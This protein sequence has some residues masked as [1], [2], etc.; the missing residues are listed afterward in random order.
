M[1]GFRGEVEDAARHLPVLG[2]EVAGVHGHLFERLDRRL[3]LIDAN[4][5]AMVVRFH[6]FDANLKRVQRSAADLQRAVRRDVPARH[7][8]HERVRIAN[9]RGGE[10]AA[11][12]EIQ[13]QRVEVLAGHAR[14][15]FRALGVQ[16]RRIGDDVD[17]F[18]EVADLQL[19]VDAG[20]LPDEDADPF[21]AEAAEARQLDVDV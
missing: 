13:R 5:Q 9:A 7:E 8:R 20:R 19:R 17:L 1:P 14:R 16:Q 3:H 15:D 21:L 12:A 11:R 6:A 2:G 4:H 10:I 18:G